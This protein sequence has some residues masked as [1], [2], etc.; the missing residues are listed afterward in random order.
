MRA[1]IIAGNWKMNKTNAEAVELARALID[2]VGNREHP[3]VVI[4]PPFTALSEVGKVLDGSRILLGAQNLYPAPSGA[5]TGEISPAMLLTTGVTYVIL[6]HSERREY[7]AETDAIVNAKV[8]LALGSGLRPIVCVGEKLKEREAEQTERVVGGQ[9]DGSL[10]D[11]GP[12]EIAKAVIAYE[13]V[14]AIGTGKTATPE[15]AQE[16][17]AFIRGRLMARFGGVADSVTIQYGGSMKPENAA[18][19]LSQ[20]DIDGGLIGGASLKADKFAKI[21]D[22]V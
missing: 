18:G 22:S 5:Y 21:V 9:I 19:L 8:K 20:P 16:V 6:G 17:H 10:A 1:M 4:C 13:P 3:R 7:F 12:D 15:M 14:W 2:V 11:L